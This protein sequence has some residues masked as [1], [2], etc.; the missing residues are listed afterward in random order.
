MSFTPQV[1]SELRG[2]AISLEKDLAELVR[3]TEEINAKSEKIRR[4]LAAIKVLLP[5]NSET[6]NLPQMR[7]FSPRVADEPLADIS[8]RDAIRRVFIEVKR[9]MTSSEVCHYLR[10]HGAS[11]N[12]K[13]SLSARVASELYKLKRANEMNYDNGRY[14]YIHSEYESQ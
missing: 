5:N 2:E 4:R 10:S 14:F 6:D 3:Q 12:G 1:I 11:S 8:I 9:P 7:I 13:T